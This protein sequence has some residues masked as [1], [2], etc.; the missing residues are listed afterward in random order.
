MSPLGEIC[1]GH[2]L[3]LCT[4]VE[5]MVRT[6]PVVHGHVLAL[7]LHGDPDGFGAVPPQGQAAVEVG[8]DE[9][10]LHGH[11]IPHVVAGHLMDVT[12][13]A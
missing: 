7:L 3:A 2:S 1:L 12:A 9:E 4:H 13:T 10:L 6:G 11:L 8:P 5:W